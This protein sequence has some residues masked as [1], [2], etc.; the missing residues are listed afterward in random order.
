MISAEARM[1]GY[2]ERETMTDRPSRREE[3]KVEG[4]KRTMFVVEVDVV[5]QWTDRGGTDWVTVGI[6]ADRDA[7]DEDHPV[8]V[9][10]KPED[11]Y[12]LRRSLIEVTDG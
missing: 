9:D 10:V 6:L 4:T 8:E 12:Q 3:M 1:M 11:L 5:K 2:Q 7:N